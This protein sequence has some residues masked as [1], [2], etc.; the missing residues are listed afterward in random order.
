VATSV[1]VVAT[2]P[3]PHGPRRTSY[4][5]D[6]ARAL[7]AGDLASSDVVVGGLITLAL[8]VALAAV[9]VRTFRRENA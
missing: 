1:P 6:A 5:V 7:F 4:T 3:P 9:G 2:V 8:A